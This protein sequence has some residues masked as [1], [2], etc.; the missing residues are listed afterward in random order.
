MTELETLERNIETLLTRYSSLQDENFALRE[1]NERQREEILRSHA[2]LVKL[3]AMHRNL[4]IAR[5]LTGNPEEQA[6]AKQHLTN[7]IARIDRAIE[8]LKQ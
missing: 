1:E 6:Q 7:M 2:E 8:I 4:Q 3:Q 5:G